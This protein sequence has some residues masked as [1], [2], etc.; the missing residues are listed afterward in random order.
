MLVNWFLTRCTHSVALL[1]PRSL[2]SAPEWWTYIRNSLLLRKTY[3][4]SPF[5]METIK[6][7]LVILMSTGKWNHVNVEGTLQLLCGIPNWKI[8]FDFRSWKWR[9]W[10]GRRVEQLCLPMDLFHVEK[11]HECYKKRVE[12][13]GKE[14]KMEIVRTLLTRHA[15]RV[16]M[17]NQLFFRTIKLSFHCKW[18]FIP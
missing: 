16:D 14:K 17:R 11:E 12:S 2:S 3:R 7:S 6:V 4:K 9:K 8:T 18:L 15:L 1:S 10:R 13:D 5:W